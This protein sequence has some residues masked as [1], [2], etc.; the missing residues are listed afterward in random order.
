MQND[1]EIIKELYDA[2]EGATL[3]LA[4]FVSFLSGPHWVVRDE[5]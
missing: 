2:A 5:C 1:I 3:D 4:K